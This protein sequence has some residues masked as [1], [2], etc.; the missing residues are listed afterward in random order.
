MRLCKKIK[1]FDWTLLRH[2]GI[3]GILGFFWI[4]ELKLFFLFYLFGFF[5]RANEEE[6]QDKDLSGYYRTFLLSQINPYTIGKA[7]VQAFGQVIVLLKNISGF[8]HRDNY[9]NKVTYI[10]PFREDWTVVNGGSTKQNSHSWDIFTQRYAYD[11]VITDVEGKSFMNQGKELR[12]YYCYA[13]AVVAP[14]DG[15]VVEVNDG[16]RDYTGVG[17]FSI[18]WK[19]K[20]FRGNFVVIKHAEGEFSFTAHLIPGSI[21]VKEGQPVKQGQT[22]GLCGNSGHSTEPHIHFHLQGGRNFFT[23]TGLP[24]RFKNITIKTK[25]GKTVDTTHDFVEKG[26]IVRNKEAD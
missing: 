5:R 8:P 22:I 9:R 18:D 26:Q 1:T 2:L 7:I 3:L 13:K 14:A 21:N 20:D 23:A 16:I 4:A 6:L 25:D 24:I 10:L 11:F 12:D 17:D 19:T 15:V